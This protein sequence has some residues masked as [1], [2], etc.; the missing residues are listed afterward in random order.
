M[1]TLGSGGFLGEKPIFRFTVLLVPF[2][3]S[4]AGLSERFK[5]D[6]FMLIR[7]KVAACDW[8]LC[9]LSSKLV[10][11]SDSTHAYPGHAQ[12]LLL[13]ISPRVYSILDKF[14]IQAATT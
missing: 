1:L 5:E 8:E 6:K 13:Y 12:H 4:C 2:T 11:Y 10:N 3:A 7:W 14:R 9:S